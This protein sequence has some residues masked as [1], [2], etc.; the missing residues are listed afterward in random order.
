MTD[1]GMQLGPLYHNPAPRFSVMLGLY[2]EGFCLLP[3]IGLNKWV[4]V[5]LVV[6]RAKI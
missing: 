5:S 2:E 3:G 1:N 4:L 6:R